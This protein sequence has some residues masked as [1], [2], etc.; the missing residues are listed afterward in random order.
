M[1]VFMQR[2][3]TAALQV[4]ESHHGI[5]QINTAEHDACE[6]LFGRELILA[7]K[8]HATSPGRGSPRPL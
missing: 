7:I 4:E 6:H 5:F 2:Y 1:P 8:I 3:A